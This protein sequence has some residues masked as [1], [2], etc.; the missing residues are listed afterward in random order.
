M[1]TLT[2]LCKDMPLT[3]QSKFKYVAF[4]I[5]LLISLPLAANDMAE[6]EANVA[7][8]QLYH[9][10]NNNIKLDMPSRIEKISASFLGKP[11]I[12]GSLGEG[13]TALFDQFPQYRI[14]GFDCETYV[15]TVIALAL[16]NQLDDFTQCLKKI[17][18]HQ[19]Q[20]DYLTRNHFTGLDWNTNNQ[21]QGFIKDIT[22]TFKD[23]NNKPIAQVATALIDKPA[24]YQYKSLET[25][26]LKQHDDKEQAKRLDKLKKMGGQLSRSKEQVPY[27]PLTAFFND[28]GKPNYALFNQ[29]P[30]GAIIEIVRPNWDL[31]K[32]IGTR[33]NISHLGFAFRKDGQLIF[34][35]ASSEYGKVVDVS[36]ISYLK[37]ATESPTIK[38][39]NVQI[40]IPREPLNNGCSLSK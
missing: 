9:T 4:L 35:Q 26:R 21:R 28:E 23:K 31:S 6:Q 13:A 24:W 11:Y 32:K 17:R 33:L 10:L 7:I 19:G 29:I 1:F 37:K 16:A 12:L 15:T 5:I 38:G 3:Y 22:V 2:L 8:K 34:R 30:N 27:L 14:D 25:I 18:Y 39:I 40:I 36:L 20:V